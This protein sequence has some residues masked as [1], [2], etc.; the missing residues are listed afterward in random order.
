M[1]QIVNHNKTHNQGIM[2]LLTHCCGGNENSG[3]SKSPPSRI[4]FPQEKSEVDKSK[5]P[6]LLTA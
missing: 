4:A 6:P 5:N 2:L 1:K 3:K